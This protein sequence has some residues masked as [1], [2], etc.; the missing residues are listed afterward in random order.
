MIVAHF[1]MGPMDNEFLLL[2]TP[3]PWP[4]FVV[5]QRGSLLIP[6][7]YLLA[8]KEEEYNA[9]AYLYDESFNEFD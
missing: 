7:F 2:P 4:T 6:Y 3:T 9:W 1:H 5:P 8:A